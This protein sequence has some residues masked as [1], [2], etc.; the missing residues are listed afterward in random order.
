MC[1]QVPVPG[2]EQE[3]FIPQTAGIGIYTFLGNL[4]ETEFLRPH[5]IQSV[6]GN[7]SLCSWSCLV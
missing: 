2:V 5:V 1:R 7:A 3:I 4:L 6:E